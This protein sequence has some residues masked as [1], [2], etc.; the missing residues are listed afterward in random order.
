MAENK[1]LQEFCYTTWNQIAHKQIYFNRGINLENHIIRVFKEHLKSSL[2]IIH[3]Q[4]HTS[5][6]YASNWKLMDKSFQ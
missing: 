4:S 1:H 5:K 6:D 3:K 2:R